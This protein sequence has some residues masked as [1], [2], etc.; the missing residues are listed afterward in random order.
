MHSIPAFPSLLTDLTE[1]YKYF[2]SSMLESP[3]IKSKLNM[4]K[5]WAGIKIYLSNRFHFC[6]ARL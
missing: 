6:S 1:G 4:G 2:K 3:M 5:Y